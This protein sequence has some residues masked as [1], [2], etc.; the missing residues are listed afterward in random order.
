MFAKSSGGGGPSMPRNAVV[1]M[2]ETY[3]GPKVCI[4]TVNMLAIKQERAIVSM[5]L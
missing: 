1:K 4:G 3:A 2:D 5:S